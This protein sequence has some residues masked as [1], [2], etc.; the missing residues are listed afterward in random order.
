M[1]KLYILIFLFL[2]TG[3]LTES[4][5]KEEHSVK[6]DNETKTEPE[7]RI[8]TKYSSLSNKYV[9]FNSGKAINRIAD[10]ENDYFS[11]RINGRTSKYYGTEWRKEKERISVKDGKTK[12]EQY[13]ELLNQMGEKPDSMHCTIYAYESLK[14]GF[15]STTFGK[16]EESHRRLW[17]KR[18][19]AGWSIGYLL[20]KEFKWKAYLIIEES[21]QEYKQC[22]NA[23][24]KNKSYPVWK[25]PDI[26]LENL[27]VLGKDDAEIQALL[28]NNE[29]GWGFSEQGIHTWITRFDTLKECNWIGAPSKESDLN[30]GAKPLF[31][32]TNFFEYKDYGSHVVV[33]PGK[34]K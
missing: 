26:P 9:N 15:D 30:I 25:Q 24:K 12:Y 13:K 32:K 14:A 7:N 33:F 16:L 29:F 23:Y 11:D 20:V 3:C 31:L 18:E 4:S 28:S 19:N 21:S 10:I 2:L 1:I 17:K 22:L 6:I 8:Y 5:N 34:G 27:F